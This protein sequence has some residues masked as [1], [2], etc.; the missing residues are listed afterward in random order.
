M[1]AQIRHDNARKSTIYISHFPSLQSPIVFCTADVLEC[2]AASSNVL[3]AGSNNDKPVVSFTP[4]MPRLNSRH[5]NTGGHNNTCA[6][7]WCEMQSNW[8]AK[9]HSSDCN[10]QDQSTAMNTQCLLLNAVAQNPMKTAAVA[11]N[12]A[13]LLLHI[14]VQRCC[15]YWPRPRKLHRVS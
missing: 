3:Q 4:S 6:A 10:F 9:W 8:T 1:P 2:R 12:G 15:V 14:L 5:A 11:M 7:A 13:Q